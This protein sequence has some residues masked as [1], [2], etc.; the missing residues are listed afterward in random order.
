[1]DE[2]GLQTV[3]WHFCGKMCS[4]FK[5]T[6]LIIFGIWALPKIWLR[7]IRRTCYGRVSAASMAHELLCF[8]RLPVYLSLPVHRKKLWIR[9]HS[10]LPKPLP[11]WRLLWSHRK[12]FHLQ[13]QSRA[14]WSHVSEIVHLVFSMLLLVA[15]SW[16]LSIWHCH[17]CGSGL[18]PGPGTSIHRGYGGEKKKKKKN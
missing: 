2:Q 9:D 3:T 14:H 6:F 15:K 5:I 4:K 18:V 10:L 17:C 13:L 11:E 1:M 8:P 16:G 12:H 7:G